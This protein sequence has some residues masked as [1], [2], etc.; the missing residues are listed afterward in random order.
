MLYLLLC[1]LFSSTIFIIFKLFDNYKVNTLQAII[2]NYFTAFTIGIL[3]HKSTINYSE[4]PNKPWFIGAIIL[5]LLFIS[6]FNVMAITSQ[7]NGVSVAA[8]AGKM[9]VVIPVIFGVF[10][11]Q[12]QLSVLKIIGIILALFAVYL[13][14]LKNNLDGIK[15]AS[16]IFPILLFLGAGI[17]D[18]TIKFVQTNYVTSTDTNLFS[19]ILFGL[20]GVFG[21]LIYSIKP[22]RITIRNGIA[23][24]VL[25]IINYYSI[26]YL[27]KALDIKDIPSAIIFSINNVSIVALSTLLGLF[28]F[29][30]KLTSKNW[31]GIVIAIISIL[32]ITQ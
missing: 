19:G 30:E 15:K 5:A 10:L 24:V 1:V 22:S 2:F 28:I 21:I 31:I 9:A 26:Y 3:S 16:L 14:T 25:G 4:L 13:I 18:T 12:E 32:L 23:G 17:I 20:A 8:V 7:K 27:L 6:V 29:K 11:Y